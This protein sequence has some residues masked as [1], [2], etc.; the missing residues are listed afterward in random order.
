MRLIVMRHAKAEQSGAP[1]PERAL[2]D[3]GRAAAE[4]AGRWLAQRGWL[5]DHALVSSAARTRETWECVARSAGLDLDPDVDD[6]LYSADPE[7]ALDLLRLVP[8]E[9]GCVLVI[10]HNPTMGTLAQLLDDG[11]GDDEAE[12]AMTGNFPTGAL[13]LFEYDGAWADLAWTSCALVDFH[14]GDSGD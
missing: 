12:T 11:T 1:D 7:S 13:A 6:G 2:A 14:V 10:G 8:A 5:P 3:R 4:S 9:A